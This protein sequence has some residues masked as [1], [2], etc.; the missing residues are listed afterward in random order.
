M[1]INIIINSCNL[2]IKNNSTNIISIFSRDESHPI[3]FAKYENPKSIFLNKI[4]NYLFSITKKS[5]NFFYL[6]TNT[7]FDKVGHDA[8]YDTR[9]WYSFRLRVNQKGMNIIIAHLRDLLDKL[10]KPRKKVLLLDCDNTLWG[11]VVGEDGVEKTAIDYKKNFLGKIPINIDLRIAADNGKPLF[12]KNPQHE[13]SKIF[14]A[15][16]LV[17]DTKQSSLLYAWRRLRL[18]IN[19]SFNI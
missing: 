11:G 13:I 5:N 1:Q 19:C 4:N 18:N 10:N 8:V 6:N 17:L 14:T 7:L 12:E 3:N 16:L 15:R 9:N 2:T